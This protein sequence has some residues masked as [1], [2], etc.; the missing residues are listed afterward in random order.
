[1]STLLEL[2]IEFKMFLSLINVSGMSACLC[3]M[4]VQGLWRV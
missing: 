1:M 2:N 4:C 3:I